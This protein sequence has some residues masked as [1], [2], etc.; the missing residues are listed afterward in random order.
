METGRIPAVVNT[1]NWSFYFCPL[2]HRPDGGVGEFVSWA[3]TYEFSLDWGLLCKLRNIN[4]PL[5]WSNGNWY[6]GGDAVNDKFGSDHGISGWGGRWIRLLERKSQNWEAKVLE[7][8]STKGISHE[9]QGGKVGENFPSIRSSVIR[10]WKL[11]NVFGN[12]RRLRMAWA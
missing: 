12:C 6:C 2:V 7:R 3:I 11:W 10:I 8:F 4:L 9:E 5:C 1:K